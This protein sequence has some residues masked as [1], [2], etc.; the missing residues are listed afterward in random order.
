M[1]P[2]SL[3]E[4]VLLSLYWSHTACLPTVPNLTSDASSLSLVTSVARP[5]AQFLPS[6]GKLLDVLLLNSSHLTGHFISHSG[7][8][9]YFSS[10]SSGSLHVRRSDGSTIIEH[11]FLASSRRIHFAKMGDHHFVYDTQADGKTYKLT[12]RS[13][14]KKE[15][16]ERYD[17]RREH[18]HTSN[19]K[20]MADA[21]H[22]LSLDPHARLLAKLSQALGEFG[23]YGYKSPAS[24]PLHA[25]ALSVWRQSPTNETEKMADLE[26][27][28]QR[29]QKGNLM[30]SRQQRRWLFAPLVQRILEPANRVARSCR[31]LEDDH[32]NDACLGMCG[33]NCNCWIW[34]CGN[35]CWNRG[36]YEHD[37]CCR[38][39]GTVSC[40]LPIGFSCDGYWQYPSCF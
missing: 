17:A 38:G 13:R 19:E 6:T 12:S 30:V 39:T 34:V 35:C 32:H 18:N 9:L 25:T 11:D 10:T 14:S 21:F 2:L 26:S 29:M 3:W 24:L 27:F 23:I 5:G 20:E 37:V 7:V 36:C 16:R 15:I 8:S 1:L 33:G 4:F 22:Q 28:E 40:Y 31:S